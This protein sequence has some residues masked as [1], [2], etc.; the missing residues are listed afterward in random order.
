MT[1][2]L[3]TPLLLLAG[4]L[5]VVCMVL[6]PSL[7]RRLRTLTYGKL[8]LDFDREDRQRKGRQS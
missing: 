3:K 6:L 4:L 8:R 2:E 5:V 7:V 1:D